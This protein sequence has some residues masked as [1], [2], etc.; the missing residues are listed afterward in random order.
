MSAQKT[1]KLKINGMHCANC[2][3]HVI[4]EINGI[5]G[6]HDISIDN[7]SDGNVRIV[8]DRNVQNAQIQQDVSNSGYTVE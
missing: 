7:W 6:I 8:A 5:N 4:K 3:D 2:I 1:L